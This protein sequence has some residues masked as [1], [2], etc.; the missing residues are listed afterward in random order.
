MPHLPF[1]HE[2]DGLSDEEM[3]AFARWTNLSETVFLLEPTVADADYRIRIFT[4][5]GELP[6]AGHPTLGACRAWLAR[7]GAPDPELRV[8]QECGIGLVPISASMDGLAFQAPPLRQDRPLTDDELG[9]VAAALGLRL[10]EVVDHR[11]LDNGPVWPTLLL[12]DAD[13]VLSLRPDWSRSAVQQVGVVGPCTR[14]ESDFEVR[15][16][17]PGLGVPE[18]PVTG[19][20]NAAI[21]QWLTSTGRSRNHYTAAQGTALGR[22]GRVSIDVDEADGSLWVGGMAL[23]VVEGT[24]RV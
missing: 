5:G 4:P 6:F 17:A 10:D 18:D 1:V 23:L 21:G 3:A 12:A 9:T 14:D 15:G 20:L 16:F 8:V 13:R 7:G 19:S 2:A 24:V 11:L 22:L